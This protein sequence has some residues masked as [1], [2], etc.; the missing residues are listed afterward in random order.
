MAQV[1]DTVEGHSIYHEDESEDGGVPLP[2]TNVEQM[3][4]DYEESS[5]GSS[6][7]MM[8]HL[9]LHGVEP[10]LNSTETTSPTFG[11]PDLDGTSATMSNEA[12]TSLLEQ[13][14]I[15]PE[16]VPPAPV[17]ILTGNPSEFYTLQLVQSI[18]G[19]PAPFLLEIDV[20]TF[21]APKSRLQAH[22]STPL[23]LGLTIQA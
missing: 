6:T 9:T 2:D 13:S 1:N 21:R 7:S 8:S 23:P 10:S 11:L 22:S 4:I 5:T 19:L 16:S 15:V 20:G 12:S 17:M 18:G 3:E 14:T